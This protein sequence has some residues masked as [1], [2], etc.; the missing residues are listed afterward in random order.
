MRN[1]FA[2]ELTALAVEDPRIYLL[3]GDIGNQ[4]FDKFKAARPDRFLN[5]GVAE[6]NM[7]GVAAGLALN[8]FR[9]IAYTINA[10]I[11]TRCYEQIRV[12]LCYHNLPVILVGVGG[13]LAYAS[14][15]PTHHSC[16][17]I[18]IL[19]ILPNMKVVCPGDAV[20]ARLAMRAALREPG[21]VYI[22][23]GKKGEPVVHASPPPFQLGKAI[24]VREGSEVCILSTGNTLPLAIE[25]G[26]ELNRGGVSTRVVSFHTVKPLDEGCLTEVFSRFAVVA[27]VEEHSRLGGLGGGI[28]EWM[29]DRGPVRARLCRIGT[30]DR[31][32]H[33][34]GEQ[35]HAREAFGLTPQQVASTILA[36]RRPSA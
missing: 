36:A 35:A 9:P 24:V 18:G 14:L 26:E 16:E 27:T 7:I 21:P 13:G 28:A 1:A 19:R 11:T 4:L 12:D 23:L 33:E 25:A 15:G 3:S 31:F 17:D 22:R 29:A 20:E 34:A 30:P 10:F 5:C 32:L 2:A 8:G 6:A